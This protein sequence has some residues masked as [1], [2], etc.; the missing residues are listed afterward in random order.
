MADLLR[1]Q[2][3]PDTEKKEMMRRR[4]ASVIRDVIFT[5]CKLVRHANRWFIK[6]WKRN[7]W[8]P[9]FQAVYRDIALT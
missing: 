5:G 9:A 2:T 8:L 6:M 1:T 7:P 4:V 3:A